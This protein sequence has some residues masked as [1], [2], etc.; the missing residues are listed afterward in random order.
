M[1]QKLPFTSQKRPVFRRENLIEK[2]MRSFNYKSLRSSP[3][4]GIQGVTGFSSPVNCVYNLRL[5]KKNR[6]RDEFHDYLNYT[7]H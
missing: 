4:G 6:V 5:I 2:G 7:S 1:S 3:T